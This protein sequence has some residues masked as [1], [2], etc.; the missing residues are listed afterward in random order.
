MKINSVNIAAF[1]KL[2]NKKLDFNSGLNIIYGQNEAGKTTISEFLKMMFYG[3]TGRSSEISKNTRKKYAPWDNSKMGGSV[4][5]TH[6]GTNYRLEREF[7]LSNSADTINLINLD[8]GVSQSLSGNIEVGLEFFGISAASFEK[9]VFISNSVAFS[10][11][12]DADSE[13]N[14]KLS[15]ITSSGDEDV[16]F[17]KVAENITKPLEKLISK[18]GRKGII[19]EL[20]K[21]ILL[22]SDKKAEV[23]RAYD[24]ANAK[25]EQLKELNLMAEKVNQDK[26][27][28]FE[29]IKL[30]EIYNKKQALLE[31]KGAF[32]QLEAAQNKITLTNGT[33][34]DSNYIK[35]NKELLTAAQGKQKII[36]EK[37]SEIELLT[38]ELADLDSA[39]FSNEKITEL[40][41]SVAA[42]KADLE[43][44]EAE[45]AELQ[46]NKN[47]QKIKKATNKHP[48][49]L[50]LILGVIT[51]VLGVIILMPINKIIGIAA[52]VLGLALTIIS[53]LKN[54][55]KPDFVAQ[56]NEQIYNCEQ[57]INGLKNN[58]KSAE[59]LYNNTFI[60]TEAGQK[61]ANSKKE[62]TLTKR[63][64]LL[65][66]KSDYEAIKTELLA[67][68]GQY[69]NPQS[70]SDIPVILEELEENID[71]YNQLK[72]KTD[73]AAEHLGPKN[74]N[75]VLERLNS[76]PKDIPEILET[77]EQLNEKFKAATDE[78]TDISAKIST[79]KSEIKA[80]TFGVKSPEE[81][82]NLI[83]DYS[84]Q[85]SAYKET[86]Q[87]ADI[88]LAALEE[89]YAKTRR[90]FS[91]KLQ[92]R[93]LEIFAGITK[94]QY[95]GI[96]IS[97]NFDI[98]VTKQDDISA[99]S[100][101]FLSK[102]SLDQ[103]YFAVRLALAELLGKENGGLPVILDD[104]FS[105]YDDVRVT[106]GFE[107]LKN[108][109][110]NSQVIFFTCHKVLTEQTDANIIE[111]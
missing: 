12:S 37:T 91:G 84:E 99:R 27:N 25:A 61:I 80:E 35:K 55:K 18:S 1:G 82:E 56:F 81:Y 9:S 2:K 111:I 62:F 40:K 39:N 33:I 44:A 17:E 63:E 97:K 89:A 38:K 103:A 14:L 90:S 66:L 87:V 101:D 22:L 76:L 110:Q 31:L 70:I 78:F 67:L 57:K 59:E 108:Y 5:F 34:A 77:R 83:K 79:L 32:S 86:T 88:A 20:E 47:R 100:I 49:V 30:K 94:G 71:F 96:D 48:K 109:A 75:D 28:Y 107:F 54:N 46:L 73:Y 19:P 106:K 24:S 6:N 51:A 3:S 68:L 105:Q 23:I 7:K 13:I 11:N 29:L 98:L 26:K 64:Q 72:I 102:G 95:S 41:N 15:N 58:L 85:L 43:K 50:L 10:Q 65:V 60:N 104:I 93:A 52:L 53:L 8:S 16:S 45:Y 21:N 4:E 36:D 42:A 74:L 69:K 92:N